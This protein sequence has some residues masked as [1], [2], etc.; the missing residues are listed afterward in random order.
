[1]TKEDT[2]IFIDTN[3]FLNL[4]DTNDSGNVKAF[5]KFLLQHR[6][7]LITTEQAF[8]EFLRNRTRII[9]QFK[10]NFQ[11]ART[12]EQTSSFVRSLPG[13]KDY[14]RC[15]KE[16]QK[17]HK[18]IMQQI[19][20]VLSD[21]TQDFI[22]NGFI[23]LWKSG[24]K[25][26]TTDILIDA[27]IKRKACGNPPGGDKLTN[28]DELIWETLLHA[29]N[30]NLIIVSKDKTYSQYREYLKYEYS[31]KTHH[32]LEICDTVNAA[33]SILD[34]AMD[35]AAI[36]AED[37]QKWLDI[38]IQ[39]LK[40]LGGRGKLSEIYE[41]CQDVVDLFYQDKKTPTKPWTAPSEEPS[42]STQAK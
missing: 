14:T 42:N 7:I 3:I 39:A 33:F 4:Y 31:L 38:V 35:Q 5:M 16:L 6:K 15:L 34:I 21:A 37:D 10:D 13:Y 23:K 12:R 29:A 18:T 8:D 19:E 1:M 2:K 32:E 24:S 27:A 25:L 20:M 28:C 22:Y 11:A 9:N 40:Q 17:Q 41:E 26:P 30:G 36:E